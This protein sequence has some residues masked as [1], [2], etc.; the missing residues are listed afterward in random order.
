MDEKNVKKLNLSTFLLIIAIIVIIV[1]G[2]F[3]YK[4]NNDKKAEILKSTE[5]QSQIN[6]LNKTISELNEKITSISNFINNSENTTNSNQ[7]RNI[8]SSTVSYI[9]IGIEDL[10]SQD[11]EYKY[12]KIT[13][14]EKIDVLLKIIESAIPYDENSIINSFGDIPSIAEIHL[15]DGISYTVA[16]G[17]EY[18]DNGNIVNLMTKWYSEDGNDKTLYKV[19][20]KLGEQIEKM[21]NS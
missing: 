2:V 19:D 8:A 21:F 7:Q 17:D 13:D 6:S 12:K 18:D 15:S 3:I 14:T 4:L 16:A 11:L 9:L 20:S 5:L 1:M 10:E